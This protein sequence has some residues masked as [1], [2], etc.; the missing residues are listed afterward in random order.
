ML[1]GCNLD[2]KTEKLIPYLVPPED[3][4]IPGDATYVA[5]TCGE[6]PAACGMSVTVKEARATKLDGLASHPVGAGALCVRGQA[7]LWRLYDPERIRQPL[8]RGAGGELAPATWQQ[9]YAAVSRALAAGRDHVYLSGSTTGTLTG[10]VDRFCRELGVE[11]LPEF[12][13]YS[14]AAIREA[15]R[16]LFG[17]PVLPSYHIEKADFMLTVGADILDTFQNPVAFSKQIV[18]ARAAGDSRFNWYHAEPGATLTG[19]RADHRLAV[20]PGSE[21]YLIACLLGE[22]RTRRVFSDR[23]LESLLAAVPDVSVEDAASSTGLPKEAVE[24]L[25]HDFM[26][27]KAPLVISGGVSN[28]HDGGLGVARMTALLQYAAR[29]IGRTVDF[30][31]ALDYSRVG[32]PSDIADLVMRLDGGGVG[33]LFVAGADPV[34]VMPADERPAVAA[35]M[36]KAALTVGIGGAMTETMSLCDVVLPES[37][38]L[39]SWGDAEPRPGVV[40]VVQPVTEPLHDTRSR[41]DILLDLMAEAGRALPADSYQVYLFEGWR[42][43]FGASAPATLVRSGYLTYRPAGG[44]AD[45]SLASGRGLYALGKPAGGNVLLVT[46]SLRFYD[47]RGRTIALL[48]EIPDPLSSVTWDPWVS[49]S[50]GTAGEHGL[51]DGD[52]VELSAGGWKAELPVMTQPGLTDGVFMVEEGTF[53]TP[54]GLVESTGSVGAMTAGIAVRKIESRGRLTH[55]AGSRTVQTDG[56]IPLEHIP[57]HSHGAGLKREDVTFFPVPNYPN[58]RWAHGDRPGQVHRVLGVRGRVL[59]SRTTSP[60]RRARRAPQGPRD[61]MDPARAVLRR[62]RIAADFVPIMCQHCDYAPCEPVCPVYATYHNDEGLNAQVY[63]RC[64]GTRYCAN[65]CPYK[66]AASTGSTTTSGRSRSNLHGQP[67]R[68][69]CAARVSWRSARSACSAS[70]RRATWPRTRSATSATAM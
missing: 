46:P 13:L 37:N 48:N 53:A 68:V 59:R 36:N 24:K 51:N 41:G 14:H 52:W 18:A 30:G 25:L 49:V 47:G 62:G 17:R 28:R 5:S 7:S 1:A 55:L 35:A 31:A 57:H 8:V 63:N 27:A 23:R 6:C 2:R 64:V 65:N 54:A 33:V 29:M 4:V 12:E 69:A 43:R 15:N 39:E 45:V 32:T 34:S 19:F 61:V 38:V 22:L 21:S 3:A 42:R 9:A 66:R 70:A 11:C 44:D 26:S 10:L 56:A 60:C 40:S 16:Q 67:R 20:R 58:Y 50:P